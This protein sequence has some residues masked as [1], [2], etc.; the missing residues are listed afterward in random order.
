MRISTKA[1]RGCIVAGLFLLVLT[2]VALK[3]G[4]VDLTW[5]QLIR[6]LLH[7]PGADGRDRLVADVLWEI[8]LPRI[9]LALGVG[10][11][12][13]M[14]GVG[15]QA[16][17]NN[18][19]ADPYLL[20]V[21]AGASLGAVSVMLGFHRFTHWVPPAAFLTAMLT[22][23]VVLFLARVGGRY[24]PERLVLSG[25][26]ISSLLTAG[27]SVLLILAQGQLK[28]AFFWLLGGF[29]Q[30][31]WVEWQAFWPYLVAGGLG[32]LLIPREL[33]LLSLGE[34][35]AGNLGMAVEPFKVAV[36]VASS[37]LAAAAVAVGG[38]I[39]FVGLVVPHMAR[40]IV[41]P[42][43]HGLM[44]FA[45]LCG[46]VLLLGADF[47][48]RLMGEIPVGVLTALLGGPFFLWLLRRG[49]MGGR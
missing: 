43:H 33:N 14:A 32:L 35:A 37:L 13:A 1:R 6:V 25:V 3:T 11:A 15:Y 2:V 42:D 38:V 9:L 39:G 21:S 29:A 4:A 20:G 36:L 17:L 8:R 40:L 28:E 7:P 48:A 49:A 18:V 26:V 31:G 19:L 46:A 10:A 5:G 27:V 41:G 24:P 45:G 44:A 30:R 12:L 16:V 34:E 23:A 47:L 22:V